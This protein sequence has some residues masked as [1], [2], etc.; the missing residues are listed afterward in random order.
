MS[1]SSPIYAWAAD[2][3]EAADD[4]GE[5]LDLVFT[6]TSGTTTV[7]QTVANGFFGFVTAPA[8]AFS[9]L[10][11]QSRTNIVGTTG[12]GFYMDN[13]RGAFVAVA[14]PESG[15]FALALPALGM[16]GAIAIK[17]RRK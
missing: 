7:Q 10:T 15:T 9:S 1:F 2:F 16:I 17:R 5:N 3:G 4:G 6:A 8:E 13:V 12:E 14:V 11:F